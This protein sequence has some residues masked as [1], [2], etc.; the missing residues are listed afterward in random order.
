MGNAVTNIIS[1]DVEEYFHPSEVQRWV[2]KSQWEALPSRVERS[3]RRVL[4]LM[5]RRG[6]LGTFFILGWVAEHFPG[7]VR[8]IAAAGHEIGCHGY[9]HRLVYEMTPE[10]FRRDTLLA[11]EAIASAC[12]VRPS[13]YRAASSSITP[14]SFWALDILAECGFTHDSS[15]Y[16]VRHDRYGIPGF[17]RYPSRTPVAGG[18]IVEVPIATVELA[19]GCVAPVGG[20]AY[21]RLFPY[22]YMAAGI[23]RLNMV[24]RQPA[25]VYLHPWELDAGQPR[26]ARSLLARVRTYSSLDSMQA[27]VERLLTEFPF[28]PLGAVCSTVELCESRVESA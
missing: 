6:A 13:A 2:D 9:A 17:R 4:E 26:L 23:R 3:T 20:G 5:S 1:V 28:A 19:P 22:R 16:P 8:E 27:K 11:V 25:C 10:E 18:S 24:E 15:V 21:L 12:G 7:L 14:Q